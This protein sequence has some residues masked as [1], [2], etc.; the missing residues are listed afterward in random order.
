MFS[1]LALIAVRLRRGARHGK[2]AH[3]RDR[4]AASIG[5]E[6]TSAGST[7]MAAGSPCC[8]ISV[9]QNISVVIAQQ[10]LQTF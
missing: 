10:A 8:K 7:E 3:F 6:G 9:P 5:N 2:V 1:P 4:A